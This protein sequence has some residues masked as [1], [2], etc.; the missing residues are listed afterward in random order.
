MP[1]EILADIVDLLAD[2]KPAL[3]SLALVNSDCRYLARS[4]QFAEIHFDYSHQAYQLFRHL[5]TEAAR[6]TDVTTR[7]FPIGVCVRRFTFAPRSEF[8]AAF[9]QDFYDSTYGMAA[10]SYSKEQRDTLLRQTRAEHIEMRDLLT[11]VISLS[12]PNLKVLSWEDPV[13]L[14]ADFFAKLSRCSA[15]H[16]KLARAKLD[17]PWLIRPPLTPALWPLRSLDLNVQLAQTYGQAEPSAIQNRALT[18]ERHYTISDFFETLFQ[19]CAPTLE[20]TNMFKSSL[21]HEQHTTPYGSESQLDS[22]IIH[23]LAKGQFDNLRCLSLAW[24]GGGVT[25]RA[26]RRPVHIPET[27]LMTLGMLVSL[28]KLRLAAGHHLYGRRHQW[29][30]DHDMLRCCLQPLSRLKLLVLV[31]DTYPLDQ[32]IDNTDVNKYYNLRLVRDSEYDDAEARPHLDIDDISAD[33]D[34]PMMENEWEFGEEMP[35]VQIWERA[36]RNRMLTQAEAYAAIFPALECIY[37]GQRPMGFRSRPESHV[38]SREAIPLTQHRDEC[39]PF[40][41]DTFGIYKQ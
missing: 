34:T 41:N 2:D 8:L 32:S 37:C 16:I 3:A 26:T 28:E 21:V 40:L 18:E 24:G 15:Q 25:D 30:I 22:L 10:S 29:P 23:I 11:F 12:L 4:R 31:G 35:D 38:A 5:V 13:S 6:K 39:W 9:Y 1:A 33:V 20:S 14:E 27:A 17:K 7:S 36:H 19:R